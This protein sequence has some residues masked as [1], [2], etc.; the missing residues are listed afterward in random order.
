MKIKKAFDICKKNKII[1]IFGN[2][3]GEQWLSDGYAVYPIFGLPELNEDYICKL[4][5]IN[6]AQRDKIRFTISQ[7]KPL[8]DVEDCSADETP[9]EMCLYCA[10]YNAKHGTSYSYDQFV[11]QIAAGK[12]KRLGLYDY[13]GGLAE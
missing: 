1:S 4:Y 6:D 2:E 9:A 12:I 13:E 8:I 10:D 7:T 5:D 3:K 11:A